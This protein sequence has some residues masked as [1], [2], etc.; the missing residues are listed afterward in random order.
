VEGCPSS[1]AAADDLTWPIPMGE[2]ARLALKHEPA[3]SSSP[4]SFR[5]ATCVVCGQPMNFMWH[6]W[7]DA[8]GLKKEIHMC[9]GCATGVYGAPPPGGAR[10]CACLGLE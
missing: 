10:R 6:L 8:G 4:D 9:A 2:R 1:R 7:L 5:Q 3:A